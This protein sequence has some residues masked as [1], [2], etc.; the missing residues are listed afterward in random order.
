MRTLLLICTTLLLTSLTPGRPK[1]KLPGEFVKIPSGS[2][3]LS[4]STARISMDEFF[5]SKY[6]VS[7]LQYRTFFNE[8]SSNMSDDEK[9]KIA[10][11][12]AAWSEVLAYADQMTDQY[13]RHPAFN[14]YPVVNVPY[15]G[16]VRYCQ[17]LQQKIQTDNPGFDIEVE[18]PSRE[19]WI[20]AAMGGRSQA[21]FPWGNYFLRNKK[22]QPMCN[23][24]QV[25]EGSIHR[26]RSTGKPEISEGNHPYKI[27]L[28]AS[29]KSFYPSDFGLYNICGNAAEM[30]KDKGICLGGSWNDY[31]GD[32]STR[33][34]AIYERPSPTVGFRPILVIKEKSV[35][36]D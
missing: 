7:N 15:E 36:T 33:A 35:G 30:I 24:K 2:F 12:T 6:E 26:N 13:Y 22:G 17:W 25:P 20:Y 1:P 21:L 23:Y 31:G 8:V 3:V 28:T 32:I 4:D 14:Q 9:Q 5:M 10:C 16:A 18:L 11:D 29:V 27:V 34:Q 19:Q